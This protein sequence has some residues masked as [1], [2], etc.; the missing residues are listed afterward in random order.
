MK[1]NRVRKKIIKL[2]L[3]IKSIQSISILSISNE[4]NTFSATA[5]NMLVITFSSTMNFIINPL[6]LI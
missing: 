3:A 6:L 5:L 1:K 4:K 2:N